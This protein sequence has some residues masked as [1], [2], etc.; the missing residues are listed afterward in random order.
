MRVIALINGSAT[1]FSLGASAMIVSL[2]VLAAIGMFAGA[3]IARRWRL[4]GGLVALATCVPLWLPGTSIAVSEIHE[5]ATG[6]S[7]QVVG[8]CAVALVI[9]VSF[10]LVPLAG[11][12]LGRQ[13]A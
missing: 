3:R 1:G 10:V 2:F 6:T 5:S 13:L 4:L 11:W 8:V 12:R 7:P 9:V